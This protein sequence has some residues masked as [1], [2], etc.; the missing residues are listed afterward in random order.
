[1]SP[2]RSLDD[3]ALFRALPQ[4]GR[5]VPWARLGDWPTPVEP[6]PTLGAVWAKREDLTAARYGGNKVR[7]LEAMFGRARAAGATRIWA[8]GA[9]GSNHAL[10][11]VLHADA[12][13]LAAGA[14]VFPQPASEPA[15]ANAAAILSARPR[16]IA[17]GS[18]IELPFAMA[19]TRRR[20]GGGEVPYVMPPGGATAEGALGAMSAAFELTEQAARGELPWPR[21]VVVAVGSGCTSAGLLAGFHLAHALGLAPPP[22]IV[23]AVRVTPWPVTSRVRIA[24]IARLTIALVDQLRGADSGLGLRALVAG[25]EVDGR[26]LGP[27]YGRT[28]AAGERTA[29][30][31]HAA[32]APAVD[33]VYSA[34]AAAALCELA[35]RESGPI[36]F[37]ATKSSAVL[38][39]A[40]DDAVAAAPPALRRWLGR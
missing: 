35:A 27:G 10:A 16:V 31:M 15:L 36:V 22:P 3:V 34:K 28:T 20:R 21:R 38:P 39:Q 18:V 7:T 1:M 5:Q 13:G 2:A 14:I 30:R 32:S 11:T 9:Y 6:V 24:N 4:V 25:L 33:C 29:V 19:V 17:I 12:V 37:W 8:T 40:S 23:T 26:W